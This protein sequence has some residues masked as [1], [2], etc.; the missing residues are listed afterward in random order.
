MQLT[1]LG[2]AAMVPT[3]ERNHSGFLL[4]FG[5]DGLLFDCGEGIQRQIKTAGIKLTRVTKILISHWHGDH[6]LGLPGLIQ[7][8]GASE[9]NKTLEIYGP[10]GT[11]ERMKNMFKA[12]VFDRRTDIKIQE[13][14]EGTI[15][16][17]NKFSLQATELDHKIKT[18]GFCFTEKDK[19]RIDVKAVK[20]LGIPEG[21]LLGKLQEN[22]P[23]TFK[24]KKINPKDTTYL[25]KGKKITY[26]ADTLPCNNSYKLAKDSDVLIC[27][28]TYTSKLSNKAEEYYHMTAKQAALIANKADVK[29]LILTHFSNRYHSTQELEEDARNVFDN[30]FAAYDFMKVKL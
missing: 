14:K 15:L 23:I 28:S 4:E 9:Y 19:R 27:E 29:K 8:L 6:V 13:V 17:N 11:K 25:E 30:S 3:K 12:F 1:F 10:I 5:T 26:I 2:T 18:L 24:G 7:T 20:K 16:E 21:P 22:K